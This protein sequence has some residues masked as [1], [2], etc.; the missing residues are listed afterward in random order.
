ML[1]QGI[2]LCVGVLGVVCVFV[3]FQKYQLDTEAPN[4]S[5]QATV[6]E[7]IHHNDPSS[8]RSLL[9]DASVKKGYEI[10]PSWFK[11]KMLSQWSDRDE[12]LSQIASQVSDDAYCVVWEHLIIEDHIGSM[13]RY[14]LVLTD[15]SVSYESQ[16]GYH[17]VIQSDSEALKSLVV[18]YDEFKDLYHQVAERPLYTSD[19]THYVV[20][21]VCRNGNWDSTL[22]DHHAEFVHDEPV[23]DTV[24]PAYQRFLRQLG[25]AS[26]LP[27][28]LSI[29]DHVYN[30]EID[31]QSRITD[32]SKK[33]VD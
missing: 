26:A 31:L 23:M 15:A 11:E 30:L 21:S 8:F 29:R 13:M 18:T 10:R 19:A 22:I 17:A 16:C 14:A 28:T 27:P 25:E 20:V 7:Q 33:K 3:I 1:K 2:I 6:A 5:E 12:A 24:R 9:T 4:S 32:Q